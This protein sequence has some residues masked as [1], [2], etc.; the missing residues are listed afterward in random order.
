MLSEESD[1]GQLFK[2]LENIFRDLEQQKIALDKSAIVAF[3]DTKG[4]ITYV[5]DRFCEISQYDRE[6]LMGEN[7]RIINSGHH[8]PELSLIHI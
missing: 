6:E 3:T 7:H 8:P 4:N 1:K 2:Y 5:N